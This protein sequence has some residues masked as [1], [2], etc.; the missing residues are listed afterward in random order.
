MVVTDQSHKP[1]PAPAPALLG[2]VSTR[3]LGG[4]STR[5]LV[6]YQP[7]LLGGV[8]TRPIGWRINPSLSRQHKYSDITR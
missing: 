5:L 7:A 2:G 1:A 3:L 6:A 4:V 8:S